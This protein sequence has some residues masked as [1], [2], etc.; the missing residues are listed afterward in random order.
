MSRENVTY[1]HEDV[2][3]REKPLG[4]L[5]GRGVGAA[6]WV[7]N[8]IGLSAVVLAL[9]LVRTYSYLLFHAVSELLTIAIAFAIALLVWNSRRFIGN[10]YLKVIGIGY[11]ACAC[12]DLIHTLAFRGMNIFPGYGPNLTTQLWIAARYLQAATLIIAPIACGRKPG[13]LAFAG[14]YALITPLLAA[15]VFTGVFPEC[16]REGTGLTAFKIVSEY[17]IVVLIIASIFLLRRIRSS[18]TIGTYRLLV[19][20]AACAACAEIAF[21]AYIG[22]YDFAN[23]AGHFL[24]LAS[25]YCICR[26][27]II[28]GIRDPFS[29]VFRELKQTEKSLIATRKTIEQQVRDRTAELELTR[30]I[31][32]D[33]R[34]HLAER[35]KEQDCLYEV[36][37][38]T[39]D[40]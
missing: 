32:E 25:Y 24:K 5:A 1:T 6:D 17:V 9:C 36:F 2:A 13:N 28:T 22:L 31:L 26:A 33:E 21:T 11:A 8:V 16:Y 12:L 19:A 29:V 18:F 37:A 34:R 38:M 23:M 30:G 7:A 3:E 14:S 10:D 15:A 27:I 20:S 35:V 39:D 4:G 40:L